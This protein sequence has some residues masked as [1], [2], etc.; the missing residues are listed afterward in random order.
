MSAN[1]TSTTTPSEESIS[2]VR[3]RIKEARQL[4][5]QM[6]FNQAHE[7]LEGALVLDP[8]HPDLLHNLG[9][10]YLMQCLMD[11]SI[12]A[13]KEALASDPSH[14]EAG[15]GLSKAFVAAQRYE[16]A[17]E[18]LQNI[19]D[20]LDRP[21]D[22]AEFFK[23]IGTIFSLRGDSKAA[24]GFFKKYAAQAPGKADPYHCL[25][26]AHMQ[27]DEVDE[28][29]AVL[30]ELLQKFPADRVAQVRQLDLW[31]EKGAV[32]KLNPAIDRMLREARNAPA[33]CEL[34]AQYYLKTGQLAYAA[35]TVARLQRQTVIDF[36]NWPFLKRAASLV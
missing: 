8:R 11:E 7:V 3:S 36:S 17:I 24:I 10:L 33:S 5:S 28:A 19:R 22:Q 34:A 26:T 6:E 14:V 29:E 1:F 18:A 2:L 4:F 35:R 12:G 21:G 20:Y 25:Y 13:Y 15:I 27:V 9:N 23:L 31:A 30:E 32:E 16:E